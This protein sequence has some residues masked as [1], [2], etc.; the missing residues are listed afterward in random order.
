M[1]HSRFLGVASPDPRRYLTSARYL[2][3]QQVLPQTSYYREAEDTM[4]R[5]RRVLGRAA[6]VGRFFAPLLPQWHAHII[7]WSNWGAHRRLLSDLIA[8]SVLTYIV[9]QHT[10]DVTAHL[11]ELL[12]LWKPISRKGPFHALDVIH[13]SAL[14]IM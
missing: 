4:T 13:H 12:T 3:G 2:H 5:R 7:I 14:G 11:V 1:G 9:G 6:V 10:Y 8:P